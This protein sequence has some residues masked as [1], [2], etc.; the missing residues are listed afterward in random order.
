MGKLVSIEPEL[1]EVSKRIAD[2]ILDWK[3]DKVI[4]SE[5][6]AFAAFRLHIHLKK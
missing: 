6:T 2:N 1:D 4:L 5:V 3:I